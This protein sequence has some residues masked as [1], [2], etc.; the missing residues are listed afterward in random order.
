MT[1]P[2]LPDFSSMSDD[3]K[4]LAVKKFLSESVSESPQPYN[5]VRSDGWYSSGEIDLMPQQFIQDNLQAVLKS[6]ANPRK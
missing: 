5:R 4:K 6:I 1:K 2:V 3:E